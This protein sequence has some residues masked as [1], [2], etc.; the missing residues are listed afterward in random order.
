MEMLKIVASNVWKI[1]CTLSGG[2][3]I[4]RGPRVV[5]EFF[6][7]R[8]EIKAEELGDYETIFEHYHGSR[9]KCVQR[10]NR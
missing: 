1:T 7:A 9:N 4:R 10:E 2:V 5:E 8:G 6:A 3:S